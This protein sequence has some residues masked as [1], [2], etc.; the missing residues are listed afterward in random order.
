VP[1]HIP[2]KVT[3]MRKLLASLALGLGFL[4]GGAALAQAPAATAPE[5]PAAT[6]ASP[7]P[8]DASA[9][10]P[11]AAAPAAAPAAAEA[12]PRG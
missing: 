6:A 8:A 1:T 5:A 2:K 10:A 4:I 3:N 7:A 12:A 9:A 11:A